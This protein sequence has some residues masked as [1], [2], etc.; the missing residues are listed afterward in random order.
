MRLF[1]AMALLLPAFGLFGGAPAHAEG[2][3]GSVYVLTNQTAGNSVAIY[4]R[5]PDGT[6]TAAGMVS[7]G[8][9]GTGSGL[10]SQGALA[11]SRNNQWLFAVNAGS[12]DISVFSVGPQGLTIVGRTASGGIRPISLTAHGNLLYVLNA[13][14]SGNITGFT[15]G[16]DGAL[17]A[18]PG[19]TQPLSGS[20]TNPAQVS[21]TPDGTKLVVSEKA[22][23]I[24]STYPVGSDGVA[25][26]RDGYPSPGMTPF[27]FDFDNKGHLIVSEAFGGAPNASALTSYEFYQDGTLGAVSPSVGTHQTAACWTAVSKDGRFAYTT[28]AGSGS[29][30]GYSIAPDGSL[31]LLDADGRTGVTG[32]GSSPIDA[33]FSNNSRFLYVLTAGSHAIHTFDVAADGSLTSMD[34]D[35]GLPIGAVGLAAR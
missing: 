7:T 33:A 34:L 22:T 25:G 31:T 32:D 24:I 5:A 20:A 27:G 30:S 1:F 19:S 6:L 15:I 29:I 21:F 13:G 2:N 28:N 3:T 11:L 4:D 9:T 23:N 18:I 35:G 16:Q 17:S 26:V 8:G 14:G 12:N 10:G